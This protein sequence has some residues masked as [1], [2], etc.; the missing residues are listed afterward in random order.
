VGRE[1]LI[2]PHFGEIEFLEELGVAP[3]RIDVITS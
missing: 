2:Q 3:I 1:V